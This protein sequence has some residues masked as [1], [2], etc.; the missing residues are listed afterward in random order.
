MVFSK[1]SHESSLPRPSW[2]RVASIRS[3]TCVEMH[4]TNH[5]REVRADGAPPFELGGFGM[6]SYRSEAY[7]AI[8]VPTFL[9]NK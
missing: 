5:A 8:D 9:W 2:V 3:F 4:P 1:V 6:R 7:G